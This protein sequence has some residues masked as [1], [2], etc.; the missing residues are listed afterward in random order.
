MNSESKTNLDDL[1]HKLEDI[2]SGELGA[3][4]NEKAKIYLKPNSIPK[5]LK[6]RPVSYALKNKIE[7]EIDRMVKNNILEPVD[8]SEWA[9][10][11]IP[12]IKEDGSI[13]MEP[14]CGDYKMTLN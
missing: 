11:M 14:V 1:L 13:R 9:T 5:F 10:P 8:V 2:F 12:V 3:K 7:L 4:K 6:A